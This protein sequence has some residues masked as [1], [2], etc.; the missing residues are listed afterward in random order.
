MRAFNYIFLFY[1]CIIVLVLHKRNYDRI[2]L[3]DIDA[4]QEEGIK[5]HTG[6]P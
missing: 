2:K 5:R 6:P 1:N 4:F 3:Y